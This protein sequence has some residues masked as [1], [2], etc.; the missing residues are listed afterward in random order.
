MPANLFSY[1]SIIL[2][3]S[4]PLFLSHIFPSMHLALAGTPLSA[5]NF[6]HDF[7]TTAPSETMEHAPILTFFSI[8]VRCPIQ[9]YGSIII[10]DVAALTTFRVVS[11]IIW[12]PSAG[13]IDISWLIR[14]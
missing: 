5:L 12:C 1:I 11:S 2:L 4:S 10:G 3:A 7:V 13:L 14:Q 9:Q 8:A 6:L